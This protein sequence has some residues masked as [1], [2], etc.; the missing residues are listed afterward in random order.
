MN[1]GPL[2][3]D[4][5]CIYLRVSLSE[6]LHVLLYLSLHTPSPRCQ[7]NSH[8]RSIMLLQHPFRITSLRRE[9]IYAI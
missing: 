1:Q 6:E 7:G 5:E 3:V 2:C 9:E 8:L 4:S